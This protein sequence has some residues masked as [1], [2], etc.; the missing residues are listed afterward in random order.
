M[1]CAC[2]HIA[3]VLSD[4]APAFLPAC[5]CACCMHTVPTAT[6]DMPELMGP[7]LF[8]NMDPAQLAQLQKMAAQVCVCAVQPPTDLA[9]KA[10]AALLGVVQ[11]QE[12]SCTAAVHLEGGCGTVA[13]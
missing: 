1:V 10:V 9:G 11:P 13:Y 2:T 3:A 7:A 5:L 12:Q 4:H 8:Q 6:T